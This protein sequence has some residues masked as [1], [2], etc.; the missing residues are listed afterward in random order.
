MK[1]L[2][3]AP[4]ARRS[5]SGRPVAAG[6]PAAAASAGRELVNA[7]SFDLEDRFHIIG[8]A[9]LEDEARW[10]ALLSIFETYTAAIL[11]ELDAHGV[12]ATFFTVG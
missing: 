5:A 4:G 7:L 3:R 9:E 12:T 8:I 11:D 1:A 10:H 6:R 2:A